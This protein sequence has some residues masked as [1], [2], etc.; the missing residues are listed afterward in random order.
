MKTCGKRRWYLFIPLALVGFT[1]FG[2]LTMTLWNKLMPNL[3]NLP[4]ITFWQTIGLLVLSR[5]L[6][7]GFGGHHRGM[8]HHLK[9]GLMHH[10]WNKMSPEERERFQQ[11]MHQHM[12][13]RRGCCHDES[14]K[15]TDETV[16]S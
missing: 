13:Y 9:G 8:H 14:S 16:K 3:F 1:A 6:L 12:E 4:L 5:L 7:G 10:R 15:P 11:R 2:F